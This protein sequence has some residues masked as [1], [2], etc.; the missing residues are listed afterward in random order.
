MKR[1]LIAVLTLLVLSPA[2][3]AASLERDVKSRWPGAWVV[4]T[5]ESYSDCGGLYT[6]NR[7]NGTL[8]KGRGNYGFQPGELAKVDKIDVNR[9]RVDVLLSL[10]E[11]VLIAYREGPFTLYREARCRIEMEVM[12]PREVVKS[13]DSDSVE[14]ALL[15]VLERYTTEDEALAS[16]A[17]NG[18][19]RDPYPADYDRTL[20]ELAV[21]R[22]TQTNDAVQASLDHA[23][24]ETTRVGYSISSDSDYLAG[25]AR[26]VEDART[27]EVQGCP[28]LMA[29]EL[30]DPPHHRGRPHPAD[31]T[32]EQR[33][34]RGFRD[35][36]TLIRG[37]EM[38]ERLPACFVP[39]PP[40]PGEGMAYNE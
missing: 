7:I 18:R 11:P 35:A 6:N 13:K 12:V 1:S 8:V 23:L 28:Q 17:W 31:E 19:E 15:V 25:F 10:N 38:I 36:Q 14:D 32:A 26:G 27:V 20:A 21:W 37:L 30:D 34:E 3:F 5:V 29:M 40:L 4:T 2:A 33:A 39:V 24:A 16:D 9:S 22:A